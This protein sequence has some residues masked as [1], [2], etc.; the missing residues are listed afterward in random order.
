LSVSFTWSSCHVVSPCLSYHPLLPL[1]LQ[2]DWPQ[3]NQTIPTWKYLQGVASLGVGNLCTGCRKTGNEY[4]I[5][6][7]TELSCQDISAPWRSLVAGSFDISSDEQEP[8]KFR[9]IRVQSGEAVSSVR[10]PCRTS[11]VRAEDQFTFYEQ[12]SH[13]HFTNVI[14]LLSIPFTS[15][16]YDC[17][18]SFLQTILWMIHEEEQLRYQIAL[19]HFRC[20]WIVPISWK[21]VGHRFVSRDWATPNPLELERLCK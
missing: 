3:P 2:P 16:S 13:Q 17:S 6:D 18:H 8:A 7:E 14:S 10:S 12:R 11:T 20:C 21:E 5:R 9:E 19:F 4:E 15:T 1:L